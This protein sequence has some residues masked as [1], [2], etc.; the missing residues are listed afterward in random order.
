MQDLGRSLYSGMISPTLSS[1]RRNLELEKLMSGAE[2]REIHVSYLEPARIGVN[3]HKL[4]TKIAKHEEEPGLFSA[5]V[6]SW[7]E[8]T[9]VANI[10]L[11]CK[12]HKHPV[13]FRNIHSA[14]RSAF[15]GLS[16][17]LNMKFGGALKQFPHLV[18]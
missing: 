7:D 14:P 18:G 8:N 12:S 5:L 13:E 6:S 16:S 9:I 10:M 17:Y 11:N 3:Y 1:E 4:C 15:N 2:Y